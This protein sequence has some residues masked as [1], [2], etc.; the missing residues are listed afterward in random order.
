MPKYYGGGISM[1]FENNDGEAIKI[2]RRRMNKEFNSSSACFGPYCNLYRED[3]TFYLAIPCVDWIENLVE[4]FNNEFKNIQIVIVDKIQKTVHISEDSWGDRRYSFVS[5]NSGVDPHKIVM[6][7][8]ILNEKYN[9]MS[10]FILPRMIG[11]ILR[12]FS[13]NDSYSVT[14]S[15]EPK[16]IFE[17]IE[18]QNKNYQGRDNT[19]LQLDDGKLTKLDKE[20]ILMLDDIDLVNKAFEKPCY[21][22]WR[23]GRNLTNVGIHF[24]QT[25]I[26][27]HLYKVKNNEKI[28]VKEELKI[29][30]D[31]KEFIRVV[32]EMLRGN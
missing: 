26:W 10:K 13:I 24:Y 7:K 8:F 5:D 30:F 28:E 21:T 23:G 4:K 2:F 25:A 9:E 19:V 32:T 11:T 31:E 18:K 20:S 27:N 6:F 12:V 22:Y 15:K 29:N 16:N 17:Y 1:L 3:R 14:E